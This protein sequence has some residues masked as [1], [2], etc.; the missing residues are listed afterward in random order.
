MALAVQ[1]LRALGQRTCSLI[2]GGTEDLPDTRRRTMSFR[3]LVQNDGT[4]ETLG[5]L[6]SI[7]DGCDIVDR[8]S[9]EQDRVVGCSVEMASV[10]PF[11]SSMPLCSQYI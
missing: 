6:V 5:H 4:I 2:F 11:G 1:K 9:D 3:V 8:V 10:W 7:T